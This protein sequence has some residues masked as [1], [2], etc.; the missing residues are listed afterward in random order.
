M[1]S[2][3]YNPQPTIT[4][5]CIQVAA[6]GLHLIYTPFEPS[7]TLYI[8]TFLMNH[9]G[10]IVNDQQLVNPIRGLPEDSQSLSNGAFFR[11]AIINQSTFNI[12]HG[13]MTTVHSGEQLVSHVRRV[14]SIT[15]TQKL[16]TFKWNKYRW[17]DF[18]QQTLRHLYTTPTGIVTMEMELMKYSRVNKVYRIHSY[19][20]ARE[21]IFCNHLG[22]AKSSCVLLSYR[23]I[24]WVLMRIMKTCSSVIHITVPRNFY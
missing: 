15:A 14:E 19:E 22:F 13:N 9:S 1:V 6:G 18:D 7:S 17:V 5:L 2:S 3:I 11:D 4:S 23:S 8:V 12:V 16:T 10:K 21:E 20:D 24:S